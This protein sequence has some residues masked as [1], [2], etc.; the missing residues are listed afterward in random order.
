LDAKRINTTGEQV[1]Q[2]RAALNALSPDLKAENEPR[3]AAFEQQWQ[4]Y[5]SNASAPVNNLFEQAVITGENQSKQLDYRTPAEAAAQLSALSVS[6][7]KI[8]EQEAA[9]TNYVPIRSDLLQRATAVQARFDAYQGELKK[10][11]GGLAALKKSRTFA[12]FSS[13]I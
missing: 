11:N 13:A 6:V 8:N 4:Q 3:L 9:F 10:L 12:D 1:A 7:Q 2:T 5:L